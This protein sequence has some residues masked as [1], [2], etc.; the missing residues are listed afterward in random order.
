MKQTVLEEIHQEIVGLADCVIDICKR[1]GLTYYLAEGSLLG[2][3]RHQGIIPWDDDFDL[4]MP[5]PDYEQLLMLLE[6]H[7]PD[8]YHAVFY[9]KQKS[10]LRYF[11]Q[12]ESDK[13]QVIEQGHHIPLKRNVWIDVF[14]LDG[15]P[16]GKCRQKAY[17]L[18]LLWLRMMIQCSQYEEIVDIKRKNRPFYERM[19]MQIAMLVKPWRFMNPHHRMM[20]LDRFLNKYPYNDHDSVINP[21]SAYKQK[22]IMPKSYF[23]KGK[24]AP[25]EDH[26]WSI[27]D[28]P[29]LIL[30]QLY[31]DYMKIPDDHEMESHHIRV[32]KE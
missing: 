4:A 25:F 11:V 12:I 3:I 23:G 7:L 9:Q 2:A 18:R 20:K 32:V 28:Q 8:G 15:V 27:P 21:V 26:L 1:H 14:P 19:L 30:K 17:V 22:A 16:E 13:I 6:T 29:D 5:R 24:L 31:G 10:H